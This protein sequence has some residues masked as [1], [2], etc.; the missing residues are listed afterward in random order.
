[1]LGLNTGGLIN[2][3]SG[4]KVE[5]INT[6]SAGNVCAGGIAGLLSDSASASIEHC[7]AAN[8]AITVTSSNTSDGAVTVNR[9]AAKKLGTING[10]LER[11]YASPALVIKKIINGSESDIPQTNNINDVC[12]SSNL[13]ASGADESF[14]SG[15]L[16]WDFTNIW[17]WDSALGLPVLR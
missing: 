3:Y 9:I 5:I 8:S 13:G 1:L 14:F 17:A 16:G 6:H 11:N 4:G 12:G 10:T 7:F 2:C 15:T